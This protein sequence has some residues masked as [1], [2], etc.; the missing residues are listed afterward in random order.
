MAN[1]L[2]GNL[3]DWTSSERLDLPGTG[4]PGYRLY[5]TFENRD[6]TTDPTKASYV[7]AFQSA[8][9]LADNAPIFWL[10]TDQNS[11]TGYQSFEG[12]ATGA[13]YYV[14]LSGGAPYLYNPTTIPT[15]GNAGYLGPI[16]DY[17]IDAATNTIEFAIPRA[18]MTDDQAGLDLKVFGN[19]GASLPNNFAATTYRI[20]D[21]ATLP[22]QGARAQKIG[23]VYSATTANQYFGGKDAGITAIFTTE[24]KRTQQTAAPLAKALGIQPT[25]VSARDMPALIEKVKAAPGNVLVVGHSNT[26]AD[27]VS[28]LGVTEK[29]TVGDNDYDNLFVVVR[30][31]KPVLV[32]LH[33]K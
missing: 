14:T 18:M 6:G 2:D 13:E 7:I 30:A 31:D 19:S 5:G 23:I 12:A 17:K 3:N 20:N 22:P 29:L 9:A 25:S 21:P 1:T 32:R 8:V 10:N 16:T 33:F 26:V 27:I 15:T 11:A 28:R 4:V 24:Y